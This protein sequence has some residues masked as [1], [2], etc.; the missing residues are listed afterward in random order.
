MT[1]V[2][3]L[4]RLVSDKIYNEDFMPEVPY[5]W[6]M[7]MQQAVDYIK[8]VRSEHILFQVEKVYS[9]RS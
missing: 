8:A 1:L 5:P 7:N 9:D 2:N 4:I 3:N 6:N